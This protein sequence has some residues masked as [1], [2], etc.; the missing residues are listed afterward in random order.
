MPFL[1]YLREAAEG[2]RVPIDNH[3]IK[4]GDTDGHP[5]YI[6]LN[7]SPAL[8]RDYR[9][10]SKARDCYNRS[11]EAPPEIQLAIVRDGFGKLRTSYEALII[12]DVL[13]GVVMRFEERISFMNLGNMVWDQNLVDQIILK[14]ELCSRYIEGHLHSDAYSAELPTPELLFHE[15][16]EF[17]KIR[18]NIRDLKRG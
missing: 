14:C 13:K 3:W 12:F 1:Y 18:K 16:E 9:N 5:G 8:E 4:R 15:I 6:F 7:N 2:I 17:N 11:R 10:D